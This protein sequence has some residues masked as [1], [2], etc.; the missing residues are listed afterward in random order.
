MYIIIPPAHVPH[1]ATNT[2]NPPPPSQLIAYN[3]TDGS[4]HWGL[5]RFTRPQPARGGLARALSARPTSTTHW[6]RPDLLLKAPRHSFHAQRWAKWF[7]AVTPSRFPPAPRPAKPIKSRL[8]VPRR[9]SDGIGAPGSRCLHRHADQ[10]LAHRGRHQLHQD[11]HRSASANTWPGTALPSAGSTPA[12]SATP[13]WTTATSSRCSSRP[14][15]ALNYPPLEQRLFDSMD[16]CGG[17]GV[18][19]PATGYYT[20]AMP[21]S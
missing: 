15:T 5:H 7:W 3:G 12:T 17:F 9:P 20:N 18:L 8:A 21:A 6:P 13:T 11:C 2:T 16:S 10:W 4:S 1:S 19:D 14:S